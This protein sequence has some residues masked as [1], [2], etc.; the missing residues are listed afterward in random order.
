MTGESLCLVCIYKH[1]RFWH[2][3]HFNKILASRFERSYFTVCS[4]EWGIVIKYD[5]HF[6]RQSF[7]YVKSSLIEI[8]ESN[9]T[10]NSFVSLII[11]TICLHARYL[12]TVLLTFWITFKRF[13]YLYRNT[14]DCLYLIWIV[15]SNQSMSKAI[16]RRAFRML[17]LKKLK[18]GP[19]SA[20]SNIITP[21]FIWRTNCYCTSNNCFTTTIKCWIL[22]IVGAITVNGEIKVA[23]S[24]VIDG[25]R[26]TAQTAAHCVLLTYPLITNTSK[27]QVIR[28]Y[29]LSNLKFISS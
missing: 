27:Q 23:P 24:R 8:R 6:V 10:D 5:C 21:L 2:F 15:A 1:T 13:T 18:S 26:A 12:Y 29:L 14:A 25:E 28:R 9:C 16:K 17:L 4:K 3:I 22:A 20:S 7:R 19:F 11:K